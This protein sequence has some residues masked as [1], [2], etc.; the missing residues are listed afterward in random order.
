MRAFHLP[1]PISLSLSIHLSSHVCCTAV[2]VLVS[3]RSLSHS[4]SAVFLSPLLSFS[5][6]AHHSHSPLNPPLSSSSFEV[7]SVMFI[8]SHHGNVVDGNEDSAPSSRQL[9]HTSPPAVHTGCHTLHA[10]LSLSLL[11][12]CHTLIRVK[13]FRVVL[14]T[15]RKRER[16]VYALALR[17]S[18]HTMA[19]MIDCALLSPSLSC[20]GWSCSA[21]HTCCVRS[22][23]SSHDTRPIVWA[24]SRLSNALDATVE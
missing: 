22:R 17:I 11:Y 16:A 13:P 15:H 24:R 3:Q 12:C 8:S 10:V 9:L 19:M 18:K 20:V 5:L 23:E 4:L 2:H 7:N 1:P 6:P 21:S 14:D